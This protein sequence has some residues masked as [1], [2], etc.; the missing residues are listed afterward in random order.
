MAK[1]RATD[2]GATRARLE[3]EIARLEASGEPL[4]VAAFAR[5]VGLAY[6][7]VTH[8]YRDVAQRVRAL[9]DQARS[10]TRWSL[11]ARPPAERLQLAAALERVKDLELAV[12]KLS[13]RAH[14]LEAERDQWR[15]RAERLREAETQSERLR[16]IVVSLQQDLIRHVTP[17]VASKIMAA[18][19]C[20]RHVEEP[21]N[22]IREDELGPTSARDHRRRRVT[23]A[24]VREPIRGS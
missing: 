10:S 3:N 23:V 11:A 9:R 7:T 20:D 6:V 8:R 2:V 21:Q 5:R 14:A 22:R 12:E 13:R 19:Q 4:S 24:A 1:P 16:G 17:D 15:Q 18:H